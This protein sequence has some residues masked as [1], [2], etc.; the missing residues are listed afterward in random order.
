MLDK[1]TYHPSL[2]AVS[3]GPVQFVSI[4]G[5]NCSDSS[6]HIRESAW[7]RCF[8][9]AIRNLLLRFYEVTL[10]LYIYSEMLLGLAIKNA[11]V[12]E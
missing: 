8:V 4:S 5:C 10:E 3:R 6:R 11:E 9:S 7:H 12:S 2:L 1:T